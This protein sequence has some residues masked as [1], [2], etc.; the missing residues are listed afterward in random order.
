MR[1]TE[2]RYNSQPESQRRLQPEYFERPLSGTAVYFEVARVCIEAATDDV[3]DVLVHRQITVNND[4]EV[5]NLSN[6]VMS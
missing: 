4:A 6:G 5:T 3:P 1:R 2:Q